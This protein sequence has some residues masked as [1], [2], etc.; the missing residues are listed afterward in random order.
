ML[1]THSHAVP[2]AVGKPFLELV[3]EASADEVK[4]VLKLA[5]QGH[6]PRGERM[7]WVMHEY[8][9]LD[10]QLA[11][12]WIQ[13]I[14]QDAYV[15]Y[16]LLQKRSR[17]TG[18][19]LLKQGTPWRGIRG[20][21]TLLPSQESRIVLKLGSLLNKA[22]TGQDLASCRMVFGLEL[23][24][25]KVSEVLIAAVSQIMMKSNSKGIMI[26]D[27][28]P[29]NL[30]K[31]TLDGNSVRLQQILA[32]FLVVSVNYTPSWGQLAVAA[33]LRK[34]YIGESVQLAHFGFR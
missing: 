17:P 13:N 29:P 2:S 15:L 28:L 1:T 23:V 8:Q 18:S 34:D 10:Q 27:N 3:E 25:F 21:K 24:E 30:D 31:E 26:V 32:A 4:R 12:E 14:L 22:V 6:A 5:L 11:A 20:W 19:L 16:E 9:I 33:T 7:D